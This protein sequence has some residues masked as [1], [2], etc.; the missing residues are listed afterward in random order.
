MPE[1]VGATGHVIDRLSRRW[2]RRTTVTSRTNNNFAHANSVNMT[3]RSSVELSVVYGLSETATARPT[4]RPTGQDGGCHR[5][6]AG[7]GGRPQRPASRQAGRRQSLGPSRHHAASWSSR[8]I[9]SWRTQSA[10][11]SATTTTATTATASTRDRWRFSAARHR[12]DE[13]V[14]NLGSPRRTSAVVGRLGRMILPADGVFRR[15]LDSV[16]PPARIRE[17]V[18]SRLPWVDAAGSNSDALEWP[19]KRATEQALRLLILS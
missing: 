3:N 5:A 12:E 19:L 8:V 6:T 9:D 10:A 1:R 2:W 4:V 11:A 17:W 14:R 16:R 7:E 13:V 15:A 18:S